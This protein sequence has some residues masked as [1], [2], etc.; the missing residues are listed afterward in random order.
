VTDL[1]ATC[2]G[3]FLNHLKVERGLSAN[4]LAAYRRDLEQFA[5]SLPAGHRA[6][7]SRLSEADLV[8]LQ[9]RLKAEGQ[10]DTSIARKTSAVRMFARFFCAEGHVKHDFTEL[11]ESRRVPRRLPQPLSLPKMNRFLPRGPVRGKTALR[12]RAMLELLYS[13]GLRVSELTGLRLGDV[14]LQRGLLRCTGKGNKERMVP[15]GASAVAWVSRY[16]EGRMAGTRPEPSDPLF[17]GSG[18]PVS[19]Q[20]VWKAVKEQARRAGITDRVTPHTLRHSFATH[21]LAGG[22][23]LRVIQEMLGHARIT[24]TQIYTHVDRE[25]LKVIYRAAHPRA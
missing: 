6:D 20:R 14:D 8:R 9:E 23:D 15:V 21:L 10:A 4:T 13:S 19:R 11:V 2:I 18:G 22:A 17:A 16:L 25:R 3:D 12:D 1:F 7:L 24:T 5:A